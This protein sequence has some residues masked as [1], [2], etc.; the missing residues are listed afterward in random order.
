M[1]KKQIKLFITA[2]TKKAVQALNKVE[3][4]QKDIKKQN[5]GLKKSFVGLGK[6]TAPFKAAKAYQKVKAA[7]PKTTAITG[8]VARGEAAVQLSIDPYRENLAN[9]IGDLINDDAEGYFGYLDDIEKYLLEPVKSSQE[10]TQL[11]NRIS[12]L[13]EGLVITSGVYGLI[14]SV[15][16]VTKIDL[17]NQNKQL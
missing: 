16:A 4:G 12:L 6:A 1:D 8:A 10:K 17:K 13:A 14:K 11:E 5:D 7:A 2:E 3:K 9:I 15:P